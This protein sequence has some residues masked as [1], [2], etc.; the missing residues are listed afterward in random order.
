MSSPIA[1]LIRPSRPEAHV[2]AVSCTVQVPDAGG[3]R[4]FLPN[5]IPGSYLI[6]DFAKHVL[7]LEA[8]CGGQP[9]AVS[10]LSKETW[11]CAPCPGPLTV[12]YEVYAWDFSVRGAHVDATHGYF[13]GTSV[14]LCV[15]GQEAASCTLDIRPPPGECYRHWQ[16]A[17]AMA[18]DGAPRRG[19]G[20]YR[21]EDY[22]ELVDHPVELGE[23]RFAGFTACGVPHEVAISGRQRSDME[24]LC[25]DIRRV[26]EQHIRFFGEPAPMERYL[27]L[28]MAV[29]EG[30]GGLEHRASCS[31]MCNRWDLPGPADE[32][33]MSEGYRRL[34]CL[35]SHEYFHTWNVKRIRPAAFVHWDLRRESYTRMLWAFEGITSYYDDLALRRSGLIDEAGYLE[36]IGQTA[37]RVWRSSGRHKQSL[38]ESSFD[39]WT[40]FYQQ[41][42]NA[43]NAI[44]SYYTKGALAALILDLTLRV[45]ST[46]TLDQVMRELWER[47]GKTGVGV[48]EDGVQRLAESLSGLDLGSL[49]QQLLHETED[50]PLAELMAA[51]GVRFELRPAESA[52]DAGGKPASSDPRRPRR[53]LGARLGNGPEV[54]LAQ[55]YDGGPAQQAGLAP[56]DVVVAIDG[57]RANVQ[58]LDKLLAR[59]APG[60]RL[61]VHA[62]RRDELLHFEVLPQAAPADTCV[63]TL[64][65]DVS[66]EVAARRQAWLGATESRP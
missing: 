57:I 50:P 47:Y 66:P 11:A 15:E 53:V 52:D 43:P 19:F 22:A 27:F 61:E 55:V 25:T 18:R 33:T 1:Y 7:R 58:N 10:K 54:Q 41:D 4:L 40:R 32:P 8:E 56:G 38:A 20:R 14:F 44:V 62:F 29:G 9:V 51:F 34:L 64:V 12:S 36:L 60:E 16:V 65:S 24:R 30:Y 35:C 39:A 31:L 2:Y 6:R 48:P 21:A 5:W 17:T 26:C 3:Q 23:I 28:V 46:C 49:F 45:R 63:L 37:T 59:S 42:E 13:N